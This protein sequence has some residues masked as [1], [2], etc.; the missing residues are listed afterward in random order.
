[1]K[2]DAGC[3]LAALAS[4]WL[5][6]HHPPSTLAPL[7]SPLQPLCCLASPGGGESHVPVWSSEPRN[8]HPSRSMGI[9]PNR[10]STP[11]VPLPSPSL[12]PFP[13]NL[14]SLRP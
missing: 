5:L 9:G 1:M 4:N 14:P 11:K 3:H 13:L 10:Q 2:L 6:S 8:I 12:Y 7:M